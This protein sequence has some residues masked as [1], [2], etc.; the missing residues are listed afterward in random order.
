MTA[1]NTHAYEG[2][3]AVALVLTRF[4]G[5]G[6]VDGADLGT[7]AVEYVLAGWRVFPLG[8]RSKIPAIAK[9][10]RGNGVL[11][12]TTDINQIC[13]WWSMMP[14][15]N[16]GGAVPAGLVVIDIDPRHDGDKHLA[17]LEAAHGALPGTL[18]SMS[19]RGDGGRHL[20]F[21][22]PGGRL[23]TR[24]VPAGI[25]IKAPGSYTVLPPS[26]HPDSR[27]P[28]T[29]VDANVPPAPMPGW[30]VAPLRPELV[31]PSTATVRSSRSYSGESPAEW[32]SRTTTWADLLEPHG[33]MAV[34]TDKTRWRHP[35]ATSA[36][37]ATIT[38]DCLFV[39]STNTPFE[40]TVA[41][42]PHGIT[43]FRAWAILEHGGDLSAAAKA[44][45]ALM[46][47]VTQ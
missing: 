8:V 2:L 14:T 46:Q 33:W 34:D 38:N 3:R 7:R 27:K 35:A 11:D 5:A 26:I 25:D 4:P 19:G 21:V 37:S 36:L 17:E 18:T 39:Y 6:I 43:R 47:R 42:D 20:Y 10:D 41:D 29:W 31:A 1:T 15:F 30:L 40:A 44:A 12:A 23:S 9:A 32:F 22:H 45:R 16:I 28:Y 24:R 13:S